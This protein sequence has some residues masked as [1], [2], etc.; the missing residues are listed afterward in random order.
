MVIREILMVDASDPC[1]YGAC[2]CVQS[3][4]TGVQHTHIMP[5]GI[6]GAD[7]HNVFTTAAQDVSFLGNRKC[8]YNFLMIQAPGLKLLVGI[9]L[10]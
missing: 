3:Q 6:D 10:L 7:L 5:E 1:K 2:F 4:K 8:F 9:S